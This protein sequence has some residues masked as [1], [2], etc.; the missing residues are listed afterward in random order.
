LAARPLVVGVDGRE[1]AGRPTGTGRYLRNLLR[2]WRDTDDTLVVYFNGPPALDPVLDHPR[3]RKRAL[4]D[5]CARGLW[6]QEWLL[7]RAARA[8]RLDVFFSPAYSCPLRLDRPRVT[9]VHD[10]SFFAHP[11]DFSW[12]DAARRRAFVTPS[13]HAS[14]FL[15]VCSEFTA[16]ELGRIFPDLAERALHIPLAADGDLPEAPPRAEARRALG[17]GGPYLLA[18]GAILNRRCVPELLRAVVR[19]RERHPELVL[20]LVG[21]NRTHPRV[22]LEALVASLGL[23]ANVRLSGFVEDGPLAARYAAADVFVALSEYE[24]FGLPALEA[25]TR[26]VPLVVGRPPS[27]GEIF[28]EAALVVDPRDEAQI[29]QAV[30][31]VLTQPGTRAG[32]VAA[33]EALARRYSWAET[34]RLTREALVRAAGR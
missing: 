9:A 33:G 12:L 26:G 22:D 18:V 28:G 20:D 24:G 21:E 27:L 17:I 32:L 11:Q 16:R 23:D 29:A 31:R 6:W 25:A 19:L 14:R 13:L 10:L 34:A 8:D 7:P 2:H 15:P 30:D 5:G 4:G 1:L 3:V